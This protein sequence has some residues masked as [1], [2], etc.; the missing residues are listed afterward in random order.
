MNEKQ[1]TTLQ[2]L[3]TALLDQEI[4]EANEYGKDDPT[5][6][7]RAARIAARIRER[8][9][10]SVEKKSHSIEIDRSPIK[11]SSNPFDI[12]RKLPSTFADWLRLA[13]GTPNLAMGRDALVGTL[14]ELPL[15]NYFSEFLHFEDSQVVPWANSILFLE[16]RDCELRLS[17]DYE[18]E[19][20][21]VLVTFA[22]G[23]P[24]LVNNSTGSVIVPFIGDLSLETHIGIV[25]QEIKRGAS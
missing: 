4:R 7:T 16:R 2:R 14:I 18:P 11:Y 10:A 1:L 5:F 15:A 20:C 25:P 22:D 19:G 24:V 17:L 21:G 12:L 3:H 9:D 8:L 23:D 13:T 6:D